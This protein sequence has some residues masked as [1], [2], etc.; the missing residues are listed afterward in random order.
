MCI[1]FSVPPQALAFLGVVSGILV[2]LVVFFLYINKKVCFQ[3]VGG[4][5]CIDQP[6]K[7]S[8]STSSK[9][10]KYSFVRLV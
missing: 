5:P 9:L 10:G 1:I 8:K 7:K 2:I 6:P 3:N 4:F